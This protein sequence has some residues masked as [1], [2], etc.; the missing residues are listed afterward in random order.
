MLVL[1]AVCVCLCGLDTF[2]NQCACAG[3]DLLFRTAAVQ[4]PLAPHLPLHPEHS[5]NQPSP[6]MPACPRH[7][8][9]VPARP[10]TPPGCSNQQRRAVAS[11]EQRAFYDAAS[12]DDDFAEAEDAWL[13]SQEQPASQE[14]QPGSQP[15]SQQLGQSQPPSQPGSAAASPAKLV[16]SPQG[17]A[18]SPAGASQ[19][20]EPF[21][22][23]G[24]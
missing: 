3:P 2:L 5:C 1:V 8:H 20:D 7:N 23:R 4:Q 18:P 13:L 16:Q 22:V 19:P 17:A 24:S 11:P 14:Q 9:C 21:A 12:S 6:S 15:G 10:P